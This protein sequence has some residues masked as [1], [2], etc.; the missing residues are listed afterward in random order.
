MIVRRTETDGLHIYQVKANQFSTLIADRAAGTA[1]LL[2][3]AQ[4]RDVTNPW[5][6][7]LLDNQATLRITMDDNGEPGHLDTLGLTVRNAA[8]ALW[9][10]SNWDGLK[11][12]EQALG[13]GNVQV[14]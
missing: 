1:T 3:R 10:S 5:A 12:V 8:G 11:T 13:G 6:P 7:I 9:F 2:G 4:L 14:R